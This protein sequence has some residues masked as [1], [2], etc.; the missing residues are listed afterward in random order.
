MEEFSKEQIQSNTEGKF[1]TNNFE[2]TVIESCDSQAPKG[3]KMQVHL[4]SAKSFLIDVMESKIEDQFLENGMIV[5]A[6]YIDTDI[7]H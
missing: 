7:K 3:S 4:H 1:Y 5:E 2:V 6:K